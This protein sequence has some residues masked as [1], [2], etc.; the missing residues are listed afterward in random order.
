L[1]IGTGD[2]AQKIQKEILQNGQE[3]F[4]IV[5]FIGE[6]SESVGKNSVPDDYRELRPDLFNLPK[7]SG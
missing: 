5:G 1:I 3:T 2:L 6:R 4:E 7:R